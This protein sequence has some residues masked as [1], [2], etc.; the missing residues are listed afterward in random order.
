LRKFRKETAV[1][2]GDRRGVCRGADQSE[3][4]GN[5]GA[6]VAHRSSEG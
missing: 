3:V 6:C 1:R 5:G 4:E 2:G